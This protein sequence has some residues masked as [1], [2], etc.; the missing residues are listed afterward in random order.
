MQV[1]TYT[2]VPVSQI[3]TGIIIFLKDNCMIKT[4]PDWSVDVVAAYCLACLITN[5]YL[6]KN[7]AR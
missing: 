6:Y 3:F 2:C 5:E 7:H 1:L 4:T